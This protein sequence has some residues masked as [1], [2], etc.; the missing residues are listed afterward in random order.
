MLAAMPAESEHMQRSA[1]DLVLLCQMAASRVSGA[2]GSVQLHRRQAQLLRRRLDSVGMVL[3]PLLLRERA[4]VACLPG[5]QRLNSA[6]Q[7]AEAL[8][9]DFGGAL[10]LSGCCCC[11]CRQASWA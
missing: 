8:I 10:F 9:T 6:I 7:D 1:A 5:L 2:V 4:I 3:E 11:S